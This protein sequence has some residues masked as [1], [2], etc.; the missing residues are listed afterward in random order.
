M[1]I[2]DIGCGTGASTLVLAENLNA[3]IVAV[4][5]HPKF[6]KVLTDRAAK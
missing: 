2:A 4:D 1:R 6:L 5:L 3:E